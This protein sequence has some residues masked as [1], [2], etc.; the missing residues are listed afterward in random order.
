MK[1]IS[2][3]LNSI[4]FPE[5]LFPLVLLLVAGLAYGLILPRLGF[6]WDDL[7][8][9]WIVTRLGPAGLTRYFST[10]RPF[11]GMLMNF[12]H[13]LIGS[14]PLGWQLFAFF[15][16]WAA[17]AALW[18][19]LRLVFPR[20]PQAARWASLLFLVYP[21]FD[22]QFISLVFGFF[23][24]V[25]TA[26]FLS[27]ACSVLALRK[28]RLALPLTLLS[29]L[30]SLLNLIPLDY[31]F[32]LEGLR[33]LLLWIVLSQEN[34]SL[35]QR[36]KK[37]ALAWLPYLV[38]FLA[39][40]IWRAFF[41][42]Y[43]TQNYAP[44]LLTQLRA[45][46]LQALWNLIAQIG[47]DVWTATFAAWGSAFITPNPAV[48]GARTTQA[49]QVLVLATAL[50]GVVVLLF[51]KRGEN[52]TGGRK[53]AL[54]LLAAGTLALLLAGGPFWI[55]QVPIHLYFPTSR[56]LVS[57]ML[58]SSLVFAGLLALIPGRR[59]IPLVVL[60]LLVAF[61]VGR[62]FQNANTFR[63][64]QNTMR[65]LFWQMSWRIP[66]L[67]PGTTVLI[68]DL[69]VTYYSDNSLTA[70]LNWIYA[71]DKPSAQMSYLLYYPSIRLGKSLPALQKG[72]PITED[73]LAATFTGS[74]S[75]VVGLVFQ[76][77]AC[78][79]VLE[80]DLDPENRFIPAVMQAAAVL[81]STDP[82]L[83]DAPQQP[84]RLT[85]QLFG[86]EPAHQWCYYFERADLARQQ[87]DWQQ[88]V[89]LGDQA[90]SV[91]DY[92]NDPN[93]RIPFIEGYAQAGRWE[94]ARKL[95][96]DSYAISKEVMRPVLCHLWQR[97]AAQAPGGSE[98]GVALRAELECTP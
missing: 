90:F 37:T 24:L 56:F 95:T 27:L 8:M 75:Q 98:P 19:L 65:A 88:V 86:A 60:T 18:G 4:S 3:R 84:E 31:F 23:F 83:A 42:R 79:R 67:K 11:Y 81:S 74:T 17:A 16:R 46:P 28:P 34:P 39:V 22:E 87:K 15:W 44:L 63:R 82:I 7:P 20:H 33:P 57:F 21:G 30:L 73:Y 9:N 77:P 26:F 36:L 25:L 41:F 78:V 53:V 47:Q 40:G 64:D 52:P 38:L 97:I 92:P 69:P 72:L 51:F 89:A 32:L 10:N 70:P 59:S 35:A 6:Y 43:Q 91:G 94:T 54:Q 5:A 48:L 58:G 62:Q 93:E 50:I 68:N 1:R 12:F 29:L 96:L 71:P 49:Y 13:P 55:A 80:P 85:P 76:P 45:Q 2:E 61:A 66:E 14:Y